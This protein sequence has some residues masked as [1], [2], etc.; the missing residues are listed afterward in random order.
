MTEYWTKRKNRQFIQL[1]G[2]TL[3]IAFLFSTLASP[4]AEASL[5][6]ERRRSLQNRASH[7]RNTKGAFAPLLT[8]TYL[9]TN[10]PIPEELGTLV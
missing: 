7:K 10:L 5:W 1:T 9:G 6:K 8:P 4:F 2:L 3:T